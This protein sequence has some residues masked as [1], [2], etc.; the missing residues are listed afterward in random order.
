MGKVVEARKPKKRTVQQLAVEVDRLR[1][2]LEDLE[3]LR[4]LKDA[5]KLNA[6]KPLMPWEQVKKELDIG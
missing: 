1:E 6:G 2:R 3:D 4:E 5:V